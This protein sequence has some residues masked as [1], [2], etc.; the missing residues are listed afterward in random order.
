MYIFICMVLDLYF[1][2][3]TNGFD[4]DGWLISSSIM[5]QEQNVSISYVKESRFRILGTGLIM[6]KVLDCTKIMVNSLV[7]FNTLLFVFSSSAQLI[8]DGYYVSGK[9]KSKCGKNNLFCSEGIKRE[10]C[11]SLHS[12]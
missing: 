7:L 9:I 1:V 2:D 11:S 4:F 8:Q 12:I 10:V 5:F 6:T 3:P